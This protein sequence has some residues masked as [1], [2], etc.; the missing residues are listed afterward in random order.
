M[1]PPDDS[2]CLTFTVL[3]ASAAPAVAVPQLRKAWMRVVRVR[4]WWVLVR[5]SHG[6]RGGP[7]VRQRGQRVLVRGTTRAIMIMERQVG[8]V[9]GRERAG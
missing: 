4:G 6:P 5:E 2:L 8:H 9:C 7:W 1:T 3:T